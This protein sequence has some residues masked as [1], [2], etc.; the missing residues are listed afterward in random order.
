MLFFGAVSRT[1]IAQMT[2]DP[3][4]LVIDLDQAFAGPNQHRFA[5][6]LVG[7]A[8]VVFLE[9]DMIVDMDFGLLDLEILK[10]IVRQRLQSIFLDLL[11]QFSA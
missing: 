3:F 9:T 8:V 5:G 6:V 1:V 4:V 11:K 10:R 2:G 7:N